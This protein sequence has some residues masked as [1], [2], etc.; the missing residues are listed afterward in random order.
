M[1]VPSLSYRAGAFS[2]GLV[3]FFIAR[4]SSASDNVPTFPHLESRFETLNITCEDEVQNLVNDW[5]VELDAWVGPGGQAPLGPPPEKKAAVRRF[6]WPLAERAVCD[7]TAPVACQYEGF[8]FC[9]YSTTTC[10]YT[11]LCCD[12]GYSCCNS[13]PGLCC[14]PGTFCCNL[15]TVSTNILRLICQRELT[16]RK[17]CAN[18]DVCNNGVCSNPM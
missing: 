2:L 4:L 13:N 12:A 6:A 8:N 3:S 9:C 1:V 15:S 18:G 10:C 7:I 17:C 11:D 5:Q 14:G 16:S